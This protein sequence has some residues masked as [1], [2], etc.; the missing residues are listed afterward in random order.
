M[1]ALDLILS[2][3]PGEVRK[4]PARGGAAR[5]YRAVCRACGGHGQPLSLAETEDGRLLLHCFSGLDAGEAMQ[6]VKS[7]ARRAL[8]N[9]G[10]A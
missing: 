6:Q 10:A 8:K 4:A 7:M 3:L 1:S 2:R 5:A 9:G